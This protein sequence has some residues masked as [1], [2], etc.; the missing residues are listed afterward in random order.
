MGSCEDWSETI[1]RLSDRYDCLAIDLPGHGRTKVTGSDDLYSMENTAEGV[2]K[3]LDT[4]GIT[5]TVLVGYSMGGRLALY[6]T[7]RCPEYITAAVIESS[8]PGLKTLHERNERICEDEARAHSLTSGDFAR[9]LNEWYEQPIFETTR[10]R[11]EFTEFFK[12]RLHNNPDQLAVSLRKIGAGAQPSLWNSLKSITKPVCFIAGSR[13]TKFTAI[14][15]E[16]K[17]CCPAA[18]LRIAEDCGH[19]IH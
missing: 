15:W 12:R 13:D 19:N 9:F 6:I 10:Q 14:A 3:L 1:N 17:N 16:M 4:L 8:S 7:M 2:R 11:P 5:H 18:W